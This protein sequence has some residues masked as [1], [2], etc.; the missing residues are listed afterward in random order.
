MNY[1][2]IADVLVFF[3]APPAVLIV[4]LYPLLFRVEKSLTGV[5]VLFLSAGV[6]ILL[7]LGL[8]YTALGEDYAGRQFLRVVTYGLCGLGCWGLL[9]ILLKAR[10]SSH[11]VDPVTEFEAKKR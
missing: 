11:P 5:S 7:V 4:F 8:L 9:L 2:H 10:F 3:A 1:Q 6:A